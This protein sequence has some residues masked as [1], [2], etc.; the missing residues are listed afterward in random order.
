MATYTLIESQVLGSGGAATVTFLAIPDTYTDIKIV[1]SART[2]RAE[3]FDAFVMRFNND[4]TSGNYTAKR[5]YGSGSSTASD[6]NNNG[7]PF[8]TGVTATASI[9]GNAEM[10][11]PNYAGGLAKSVSVD[12][13]SENNATTAYVSLYAFLWSGTDA[14]NR[15]DITSE[16]AT[17]MLE[18]STFYLYGISN[19]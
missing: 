10:Y 5:L 9:F 6:S 2:T 1:A 17:N 3:V 11:I 4:T 13:V 15:I 7:M 16:S 14:I 8:M 19:S 12:G 18:F